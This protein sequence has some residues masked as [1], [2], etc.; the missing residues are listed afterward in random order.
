MKK[1]NEDFFDEINSEEIQQ[2]ELDEIVPE[3]V[4]GLKSL[5]SVDD[6]NMKDTYSISFIYRTYHMSYTHR[7]LIE[8]YIKLLKTIVPRFMKILDTQKM[9]K[10]T[11][12]FSFNARLGTMLDEKDKEFATEYYHN[13]QAYEIAE[14]FKDLDWRDIY[15][16]IV[17]TITY[18]LDKDKLPS[19]E[20]MFNL[21]NTL[22]KSANSP[23][24][25]SVR[26]QVYFTDKVVYFNYFMRRAEKHNLTE[27]TFSD[28]Y[29][30]YV[31]KNGSIIGTE[32]KCDMK[33]NGPVRLSPKSEQKVSEF[34]K[35]Q[36][37]FADSEDNLVSQEEDENGKMN[38][39]V[40]FYIGENLFASLR[41][42]DSAM[43]DTGTDEFYERHTTVPSYIYYGF[44]NIQLSKKM[45]KVEP[46]KSNVYEKG[47]EILNKGQR[48]KN[49]R[50]GPFLI[51]N[52][53]NVLSDSLWSSL[54]IGCWRFRTP[55][56]KRGDWFV[57]TVKIAKMIHETVTEHYKSVY[58]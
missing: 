25:L 51:Y 33:Y 55:G 7:P 42:L 23:E 30:L 2:T 20:K 9:L 28:F 43:P 3:H 52:E 17:V 16:T 57:P 1:L 45:K 4:S 41:F 5:A 24:V 27:E 34:K 58:L 19:C 18:E 44:P 22:Y 54:F 40:A 6:T 35:F 12:V 31:E 37:L 11:R 29:S 14:H 36:V 49:W 46:Y 21:F 13:V 53:N 10:N 56:T 26:P 32:Y 38:T 47:L 50:N 15:E 8:N 48:E 39:P